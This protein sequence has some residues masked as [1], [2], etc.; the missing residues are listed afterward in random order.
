MVKARIIESEPAMILQEQKK[1]LVISDLHIGFENAFARNKIFVEDSSSIK[2][3]VT[4]VKK[5]IRNENVDSVILL[6]D[7]KSSIQQITKNEWDDV[8]YFFE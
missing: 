5:L 8:P 4:N 6:G 3:I 7:I 2:Q 1:Y